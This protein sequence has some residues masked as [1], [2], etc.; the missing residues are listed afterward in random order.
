MRDEELVGRCIDFINLPGK[1]RKINSVLAG[2]KQRRLE[3][4]RL[5]I[6]M[7]NDRIAYLSNGRSE[8]AG[9]KDL[10]SLVSSA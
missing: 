8:R 9:E 1:P 5:K 6:T 7:Y 10:L 2:S 3:D 4:F